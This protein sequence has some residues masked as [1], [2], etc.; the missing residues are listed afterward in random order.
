M[1]TTLSASAVLM[2]AI[3]ALRPIQRAHRQLAPA[4]ELLRDAQGSSPKIGGALLSEALELLS[5][6][7]E[8]IGTVFGMV[9]DAGGEAT[10]LTQRV[11]VAIPVVAPSD[12]L[13]EDTPKHMPS[14]ESTTSNQDDGEGVYLTRHGVFATSLDAYLKFLDQYFPLDDEEA[15]PDE[16]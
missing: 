3:N 8:L 2:T 1:T 16:E 10:V 12:P 6:H 7:R 13:V 11:L 4:F 9:A 15:W 14:R 5:P